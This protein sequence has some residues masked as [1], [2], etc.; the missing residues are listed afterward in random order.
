MLGIE[1]E[2]W[3]QEY[4]YSKASRI[5]RDL[6]VSGAMLAVF[7]AIGPCLV[8]QNL[9]DAQLPS[10]IAR[11]AG[12]RWDLRNLAGFRRPARL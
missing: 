8:A 12:F 2:H 11:L 9:S 4:R 6:L 3:S 7:F 5:R 1:H 10:Y